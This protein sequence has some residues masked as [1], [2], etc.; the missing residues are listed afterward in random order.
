MTWVSQ[1]RKVV[2]PSMLCEFKG[3]SRQCNKW[4]AIVCILEVCILLVNYFVQVVLSTPFERYLLITT[5]IQYFL[6]IKLTP[7]AGGKMTETE[8]MDSESTAHHFWH[9]P[10]MLFFPSVDFECKYRSQ[11]QSLPVL[12]AHFLIFLESKGICF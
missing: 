3:R 8:T 7:K 12:Q 1:I 2:C 9:Q 10:S 11:T 6:Y 4:P 5:M